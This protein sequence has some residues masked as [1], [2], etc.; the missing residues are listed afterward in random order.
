MEAARVKILIMDACR[1]NPY[2]NFRGATGL[3][4]VQRGEGTY[5]AFAAAPGKP[6]SD[7]PGAS[8][9]LFTTHLLEVLQQPGLTIDGV[10]NRVRDR[11]HK[12]SRYQQFP[13]STSGLVGDFVFRPNVG[14]DPGQIL[15]D[16]VSSYGEITALDRQ[17]REAQEGGQSDL[18]IIFGKKAVNACQKIR[19][20]LRAIDA[21]MERTYVNYFKA[22]YLA[23]AKTIAESNRLGDSQAVLAL[24]KGPDTLA[25]VRD[26]A[27]ITQ[28]SRGIKFTVAE[29]QLE[30]EYRKMTESL[31]ALGDRQSRLRAQ[32]SLTAEEKQELARLVA[33]LETGH[34]AVEAFLTQLA[35]AKRPRQT[36]TVTESPDLTQI[37]GEMGHGTVAIYTLLTDAKYRAVLVTPSVRKAYE[38]SIGS[39][40]LNRKI[41]AFREALQNPRAD[42]RS[43]AQ[44]LYTILV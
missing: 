30:K 39:A 23:L 34:R 24:L 19:G 21:E 1:T 5:I 14:P 9:G 8:H 12:A 11:V 16:V 36:D 18:A 29:I 31:V 27:K 42:P 37:L 6:A 41:L 4:E 43:M 20:G 44:E 13:W 10:F 35:T 2:A 40:E 15:A 26:E 33:N 28:L 25:R 32:E 22:M 17:M 38:Y 7:N 3:A